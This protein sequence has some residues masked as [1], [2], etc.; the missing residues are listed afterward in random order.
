MRPEAERGVRALAASMTGSPEL[1]KDA[2]DAKIT[3]EIVAQKTKGEEEL[4]RKFEK[5]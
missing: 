2:S 3:N 4:G 5:N 1:S